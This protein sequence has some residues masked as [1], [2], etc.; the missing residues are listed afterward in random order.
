[1]WKMKVELDSP[2]KPTEDPRADERTGKP[3]RLLRS[4]FL[5]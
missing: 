1:M 5:G 2:Q 3:E 4:L